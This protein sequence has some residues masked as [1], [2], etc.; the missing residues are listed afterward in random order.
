MENNERFT[1]EAKNLTQETQARITAK[2]AEIDSVIEAALSTA[3][4]LRS[5]RHE[6]AN[7]LHTLAGQS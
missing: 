6:L 3:E 1:P 7:A 4:L 2:I 5:V